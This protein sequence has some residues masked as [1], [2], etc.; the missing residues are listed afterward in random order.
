MRYT[1]N[2]PFSSKQRLFVVSRGLLREDHI[3]KILVIMT[4][5]TYA[6]YSCSKRLLAWM[7]IPMVALAALACVR[8]RIGF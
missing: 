4:I 5:R 1:D 7:G 8:F 6:L 3:L 2:W